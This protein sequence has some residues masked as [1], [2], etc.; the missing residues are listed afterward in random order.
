MAIIKCEH[1]KNRVYCSAVLDYIC[2]SY[3]SLIKWCSS[4][5][6]FL[7]LLKWIWFDVCRPC[8]LSCWLHD[9]CTCLRLILGVKKIVTSLLDIIKLMNAQRIQG[10]DNRMDTNTLL[11]SGTNHTQ[12]LLAS[13]ALHFW[14]SLLQTQPSCWKSGCKN[15]WELQWRCNCYGKSK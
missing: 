1:C 8:V 14:S 11:F 12:T 9:S 6:I 4:M 5:S 13:D 2:V 10:T 7:F 15:F 3:V